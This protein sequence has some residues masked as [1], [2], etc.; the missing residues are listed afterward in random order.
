M[1][2]G[3]DV[4]G[5]ETT[6]TFDQSKDEFVI[7]TPTITSTKWWPGDMGRFANHALVFARLIIIDE[8]EKNDYGVLPF[9]V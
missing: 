2:H 4:S 9:I 3:S 7:C 6:A 8:G 5:I 1:G